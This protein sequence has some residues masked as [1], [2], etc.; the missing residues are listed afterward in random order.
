MKK[1]IIFALILAIFGALVALAPFT[2][3]HVC[4]VGEK[5]MKCHWTA[6]TEL[7][8]G[9]AIAFLAL[10][11]LI[12]LSEHFSLGLNAGIF[13]LSVGVILIPTALI[14]VCGKADMHCHAVTEPT[15][16]VFGI[17]L[18]VI[19]LIQSLLLWKNR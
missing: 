13:A 2:F 8:L 10:L 6:Q 14:G 17:L 1:N 15:L 4:A 11:K 7:F 5:V 19:N 18:I 16:V 3:A 9:S 12:P